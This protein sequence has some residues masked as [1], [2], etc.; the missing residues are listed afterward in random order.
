MAFLSGIYGGRKSDNGSHGAV[1]IPRALGGKL[2]LFVF[3]FLD[4]SLIH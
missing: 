1:F 4:A 2:L 3:Q